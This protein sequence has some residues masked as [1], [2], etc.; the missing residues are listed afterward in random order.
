MREN[1]TAGAYRHHYRSISD[2]T[3]D[4]KFR[5]EECQACNGVFQSFA[6]EQRM[7]GFGSY[8]TRYPT[9][10]ETVAFNRENERFRRAFRSLYRCKCDALGDQHFLET[11]D[12]AEEFKLR[13]KDFSQ[14]DKPSDG[15]YVDPSGK[16][17]FR[18]WDGADWTGHVANRGT[19]SH[20]PIVVLNNWYHL[21]PGERP[22]AVTAQP[23][24]TTSPSRKK[25]AT[26]NI[27]EQLTELVELRRSGALTEKQFEAAKN[28]L[29]GI[30]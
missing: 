25:N 9:L 20:E 23:K 15:W 5:Y 10:D 8:T 12:G 13:E 21:L 11:P 16:H 26:K 17:E 6:L 24:V 7:R 3:R 18:F 19:A 4:A 22:T 29:L 1:K 27:A 28:A 14:L 2:R 30:D